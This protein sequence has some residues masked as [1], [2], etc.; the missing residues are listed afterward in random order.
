MHKEQVKKILIRGHKKNHKKKEWSQA[1][2][3]SYSW[4]FKEWPKNSASSPAEVNIKF[5]ADLNWV[6]ILFTTLG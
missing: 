3:Y 2:Y 4:D 1:I 5:V 6:R